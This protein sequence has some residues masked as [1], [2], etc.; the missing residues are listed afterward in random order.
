MS[1]YGLTAAFSIPCFPH[2]SHVLQ[3]SGV[4]AFYILQGAFKVKA[5]IS[6]TKNFN[7]LYQVAQGTIR[8]L[9]KEGEVYGF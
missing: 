5:V 4:A 1:L 7:P 9:K 6:F 8:C 2:I 3:E